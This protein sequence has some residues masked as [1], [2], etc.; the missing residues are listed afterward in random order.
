MASQNM[1]SCLKLS[2][3]QL[4]TLEHNFNNVSKHPDG[5]TL[6]LVAAECGLTEEE[7]E[8]WFKLRNEQ[9]RKAEGLRPKE[10]SVFE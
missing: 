3:D 5:T 4:K 9:W 1:Q 7:T 8:N 2:E 6:I 10:G